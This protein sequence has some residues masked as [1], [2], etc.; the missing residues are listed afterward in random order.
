MPNGRR[1]SRGIASEYPDL[2]HQFELMQ[3]NELPEGW[4]TALPSFPADPKGVASRDASAKVLNAVAQK[5]PWLL[6]GAADL[7]PSTKTRLT[8][9]EAGDF[10]AANYAGRNFHFGIR[11]HAMGAV[12]NGM[13]LSNLRV[14]GSG[15]LIFSDYMRASIRLSAIMELP[16]VWVFTHD[17]IGVGEDGPT[18][19]PI[20]HL[21]SLRAMPGMLTIRPADANEVTE[22]WRVVLKLTHHPACLILSRQALPTFDRAKLGAAS[23]LAKGAYVLSDPAE[24][25]PEVILIGT[26]SEVSLCMEA[27]AALAA[28]GVRARVVSMPCWELFEEQDKAYRDE[29]LPPGILARVSV[30]QAAKLGWERYVGA[31]GAMIGMHTFGAS[32]PLSAL[33]AK[34]GF[35]KASV[36][37]AAKQQIALH[38]GKTAH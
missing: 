15:F 4:E 34:F 11:E 31:N 33:L 30:E 8:F 36:V 6:G 18:H 35:T 12:C 1:C 25:K 7:A 21:A 28:E 16:V 37:E 10:E 3:K 32:A 29:V 27:Q 22:A 13:R 24:G 14:Y 2:A 9:D 5:L 38:A 23:G 19:Q 20:E 17:S 26:G